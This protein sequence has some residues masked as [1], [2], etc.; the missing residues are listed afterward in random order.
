MNLGSKIGIAVAILAWPCLSASAAEMATLRN[1]FTIRH[2][3]HEVRGDL[4]R[5]YLAVAPDNYVEVPTA[6]ILSY[7]EIV[8]P[9][10]PAQ[11]PPPPALTLDRV[12]SAA[13]T[14][15]NI[16]PD[17]I[18]SVIRAES[19]FNPNAVSP[20]GAQGLM[21]LMPQTA[22]QLGVQDAFD[23][24]TN[25]EGGTRYLGQL[26]A[27]YHNDIRMALAA[28]NAGPVRVEQYQGVPPYR[29]TR[30]YVARIIR[31]FNR[32]KSAQRTPQADSLHSHSLN[33]NSKT[34][35]S[36]QPDLP[37]LAEPVR[38]MSPVETGS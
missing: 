29:E 22:A 27:R 4:T 15:N 2:E 25:V 17:L 10:V 18:L 7:E 5:L 33:Q 8:T 13:S 14:H 20:K 19:G 21:Q 28:Y 37:H 6:E 3:R 24:V 36:S 1:G 23:P 11:E 26:L 34:T 32:K 16:D 31:D 30:D 38:Y 9:V 35:T 12:V